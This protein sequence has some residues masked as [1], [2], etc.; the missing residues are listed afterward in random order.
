M[1][2]PCFRATNHSAAI[3]GKQNVSV[4]SSHWWRFV[5]EISPGLT[6][7]L[8]GFLAAV[9]PYSLLRKSGRGRARSAVAYLAGLVT[10]LASA[11]VVT[12]LLL[13]TVGRATIA[14]AGLFSAFFGPFAGMVRATWERTGRRQR[15]TAARGYSR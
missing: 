6:L 14:E 1:N 2:S 15:R 10:G 7:A 9:P 3:F 12:A 13:P 8:V 5:A 4:V 11:V